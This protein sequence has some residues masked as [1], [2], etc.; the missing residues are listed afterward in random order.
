M[1]SAPKGVPRSLSAVAVSTAIVV[2]WSVPIIDV[3]DGNL[4]GY[5]IKYYGIVID[6]EERNITM[7]TSSHDNQSLLLSPL[8]E[9]TSYLISVQAIT[10]GVGS[11]VSIRLRTL[12]ASKF[13]LNRTKLVIESVFMWM[14][15]IKY[16][17]EC[18][19]I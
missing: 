10:D 8:E 6:T 18:P 16:L 17:V 14:Y 13:S 15:L 11:S 9:Y 5:I 3:L 4:T 19:L 12:E 1:F 7:G 2:N